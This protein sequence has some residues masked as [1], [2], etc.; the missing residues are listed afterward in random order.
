MHLKGGLNDSSHLCREK[1]LPWRQL[2]FERGLIHGH[3]RGRRYSHSSRLQRHQR[4]AYTAYATAFLARCRCS[5]LA[6]LHAL[7]NV[8]KFIGRA[9][10]CAARAVGRNPYI[11]IH[12]KYCGNTKIKHMKVLLQSFHQGWG[13]CDQHA[14]RELALILGGAPALLASG[15]VDRGEH[16]NRILAAIDV[17]APTLGTNLNDPAYDDVS[18]LAVVACT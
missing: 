7:C 12:A 6:R 9:G 4:V 13:H 15:K 14:T 16:Q 5:R 11:T 3:H 18:H 2:G 1:H 17:G 10:T 8:I